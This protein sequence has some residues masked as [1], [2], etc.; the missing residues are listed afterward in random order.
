MFTKEEQSEIFQIL[1]AQSGEGVSLADSSG[2][3]LMVN[4]VFCQLTGYSEKELLA[5]SFF[6]L[7]SPAEKTSLSPHGFSGQLQEREVK[8]L[9]KDGSRLEVAVKLCP[10]TVGNQNLFLF[11]FRDNSELTQVKR[12]LTR[13]ETRF[14]SILDAAPDAMALTNTRRE[15]VSMN[16][17]FSETFGYAWEEIKGKQSALFY[18]NP[19]EF[20]RQGQIRFNLKVDEDPKPYVVDYRRKNGEVFPGETVAIAIKGEHNVTAGFL[21]VIRDITE[22]KRTEKQ[23][24]RFNDFLEEL[25]GL[26]SFEE[27]LKRITDSVVDVFDADFCRIWISKPGDLCGNGCPHFAVTE[28]PHACRQ[29]EQC[30]HLTSSSGRYTG[31][32]SKMHGR[33]PF[34]CYKIG[35]IAAILKVFVPTMFAV[36]YGSMITTGPD[37]MV[38]LL[39]PVSGFFRSRGL[40][41]ECWRFSASMP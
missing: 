19:D 27:K 2:N 21:T 39:L 22:R 41:L 17:A 5:M 34:G 13:S 37:N 12:E 14:H 3:C 29:Q 23:I 32:R 25:L 7:L 11:L 31:L 30:L 35:R 20:E 33:V 40:P 1:I 26:E 28:G 10:A 24:R 36:I 6:D 9:R 16:P 4:S 15:L 8:L 38:W 18:E